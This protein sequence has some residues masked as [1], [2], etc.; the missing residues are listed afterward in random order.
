MSEDIKELRYGFGKNWAEFVDKNFNEDVVRDAQGRLS[1]F[2]RV[3]SLTGRVFLD[4]GCGSGLHS[5]AAL[6]LG[7][8]RVVSFDYDANSVATT[9]R[10]RQYAGNPENWTVTQGSVL[11]AAFM[12]QLPKADIV[13]SWGV[14]HHTGDMWTA[15]RNAALA[16]KPDGVFFIALYASEI[17]ADPPPEYWVKLKRRYNLRGPLGKRIMEWAYIFR[18]YIRPAIKA[19]E[20]PISVIR[21]YGYRGMAF[22]TDVRDWLGGYPIE[23]SSLSEVQ[24]FCGSELG[25]DLVNVLTGQGC[26]EYLFCRAEANPA[27]REAQKE[28]KLV[29]LP[30]PFKALGGASYHA[31]L[32][33]LV[34]Q[35]DSLAD[36][37]RSHLMLYEDGKMLGFAHALNDHIERFGRGR[38]NHWGDGIY[39]STRDNSDPN[40]NGRQYSYCERF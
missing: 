25:L 26:S 19:G 40:V 15:I 27:W 13:Y 18:Q 23:F 30:G 33:E 3:A 12:E 38:F 39:F 22:W 14:L 20:N 8:E 29:P 36:H 35:A 31:E 10:L 11:D 6:R 1:N 5:L 16:M 4:I 32:P 24:E 34:D 28:R 21:N 7:A 9:R 37:R 17:Y 2:L